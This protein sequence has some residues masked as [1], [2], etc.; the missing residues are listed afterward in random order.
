MLL[1]NTKTVII[2]SLLKLTNCYYYKVK[3]KN[4]NLKIP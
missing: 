3:N 1:L 4:T 2:F